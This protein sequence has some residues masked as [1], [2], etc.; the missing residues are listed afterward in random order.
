SW[1]TCEDWPSAWTPRPPH[2]HFEP[3]RVCVPDWLGTAVFVASAVEVASFDW[4]TE[5]SFPQLPIRPGSAV[6][7]NDEPPHPHRDLPGACSADDSA[8][9]AWPTF[10][11]W[12]M[13]WTPGPLCVCVPVW[14]GTAVFVASADDVA[15]FDCV[16]LP[17]WHALHTRTG[18]AELPAP[19]CFADESAAL[20]WP[21]FDSWP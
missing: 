18:S 10:D 5:P 12:P 16:T 13:A 15:S 21:T 9:A 11:S 8:N 19:I 7:P 1:W 3:A 20:S 6:L 4:Y 14:V 2:P 17:P